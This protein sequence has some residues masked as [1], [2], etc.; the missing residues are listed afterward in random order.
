MADS[1]RDLL[2][3][4]GYNVQVAYGGHEAVELLRRASFK[5]VVTDLRMQ[6]TDGLDVIHFI[7]K[8]SPRTLIIVITVSLRPNRRSRPSTTTFSSTC[9]KPFSFELFQ[10]AIEKAF[11]RLETEQ[12]REDTAA[13][14]THD[15]KIPLTSIIGFAAMLYDRERGDSIRGPASSPRPSSPMARKILALIENYLTSCKIESGGLKIATAPVD[16][17]QMLQDVLDGSQIEAKRR[18]R[19]IV[20]TLAEMPPTIDVDEPLL[21]RAFSN[22]LQNAIKYSAASGRSRSGP[23]R[24]SRAARR[25]GNHPCAWKC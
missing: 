16:V 15:I 17:R 1:L 5:V 24:W 20:H 11:Q 14:I 18:E 7:H 10:M 3:A 25:S 13:M 21:Y 22:L 6:D 23:A 19:T 4:V 9:R 12:L 2:G 8:H